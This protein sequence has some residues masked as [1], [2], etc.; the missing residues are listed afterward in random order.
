MSTV[1]ETAGSVFWLQEA[2]AQDDGPAC[3]PLAGTVKAD[4][5]V[6]GGGFVGMWAALEVVEQAPDAKVVLIE[7]EGCGLGA[8]G[9]N[10]G[11]VTSWHDELEDL[12]A[13]FGVDRAR[14][15]AERST[16]AIDRIQQVSEAEAIDCHL[17]RAG[18]FW[19]AT[20]PAQLGP[21]D[22]E[23]A[24]GERVGRPGYVVPMDAAEIRTRT[25]SPVIVGGAK[26]TDSA[27]IQPAL[28]ARGLRRLLLRRGVEIYEGTRMLKLDRGAPAVLHTPG[29]F[30]HAGAVV[31][32]LGAWAAGVRELRRAVVPVGSHIVLTEPIPDRI[33]ELGWTGGELLGDTRLLVHYAQVTRDGRIA[34]GRGG[35]AIGP[36]GRVLR[37]HFVDPK[38]V[39][40][41]AAGFRRWFPQLRDVALT[42]AWGGAVDR[43]PGHLPFTGSLGDHDNI[44]YA[45]GFSGNGVGPSA[46]LGRMV[47]RRALGVVDEYTRNA[48]SEGPPSYLPPEP[49]RI[50]G[51]VVVRDAVRRA[52]GAEERGE[53]AGPVSGALRKLVWFTTPR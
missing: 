4:V 47:G 5:C 41:V 53:R 32:G 11:W 18:G 21:W 13:R 17:R 27:A 14:W 50:L 42:H 26:V 49:A 15:L 29:G 43:A 23:V 37:S 34:F 44:H 24:A 48:I 1:A 8:S 28:L 51:G 12:I 38:T 25:G 40:I 35:G 45:T 22:A 46:L 39:A 19:T 33:A 20:A 10:G 36:A 6:V 3:P 7:A 16:W 30:V 31:L 2:L 9:R 52:E